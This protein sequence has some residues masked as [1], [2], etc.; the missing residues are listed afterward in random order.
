M[1]WSSYFCFC[2]CVFISMCQDK[3]IMIHT[4]TGMTVITN[5]TPV[6]RNWPMS[7]YFCSWMARSQ[8]AADMDSCLTAACLLDTCLL[9]SCL[10]A[11]C[12][13]HSCLLDSRLLAFCLSDSCF[14]RVAGLWA[15]DR[16]VA[17]LWVAG[18]R[19]VDSYVVGL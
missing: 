14:L 6:S 9:D 2:S 5:P 11:F 4:T 19:V 16:W 1:C 8:V 3:C 7:L 17:G 18:L 12:L 15:V 13:L 10:V